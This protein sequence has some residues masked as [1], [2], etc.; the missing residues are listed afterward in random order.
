MTLA[1]ERQLQICLLCSQVEA[2]GLTL[3]G[4]E[5]RWLLCLCKVG[6]PCEQAPPVSAPVGPQKITISSH[7]SR[8]ISDMEQNPLEPR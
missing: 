3:R 5:R 2:S 6:W 4:A 7:I 8:K 1:R